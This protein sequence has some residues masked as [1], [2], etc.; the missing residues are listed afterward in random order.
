M[1][2]EVQVEAKD[3]EKPTRTAQEENKAEPKAAAL[4]PTIKL[5]QR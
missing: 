4:Q 2:S 1:D 5:Q 3:P